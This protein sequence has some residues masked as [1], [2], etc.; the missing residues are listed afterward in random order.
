MS[1][2]MFGINFI[3]NTF[4]ISNFICLFYQINFF[5]IFKTDQNV[6]FQLSGQFFFSEQIFT[7]NRLAFWWAQLFYI[8]FWFPCE[9]FNFFFLIS[10]SSTKIFFCTIFG[11]FFPN[12][13]ILAFLRYIFSW[14][15]DDCKSCAN[16]KHFLTVFLNLWSSTLDWLPWH[17]IVFDWFP[18]FSSPFQKKSQI[19]LAT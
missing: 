14:S 18:F 6:F 15:N 16:P 4:K 2:K 7:Q 10:F 11:Q 13:I 9:N 5:S 17:F 19:W 8:W 1:L 12:K 3:W